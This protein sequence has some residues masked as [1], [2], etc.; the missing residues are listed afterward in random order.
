VANQIVFFF[1]LSSK[2][3]L[4]EIPS[5][6]ISRPS[7][8]HQTFTSKLNVVAEG[9]STFARSEEHFRQSPPAEISVCE[10]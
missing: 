4:G 9:D 5:E 3:M 6:S 2:V 7:A 10:K 8:Q 1:P